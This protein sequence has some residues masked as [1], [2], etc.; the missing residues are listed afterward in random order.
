MQERAPTILCI[1]DDSE[2][3]ALR[4][5]FLQSSGYSVVTASSG[6]DGLRALSDGAG[7]DLVLLDYMMPGMNGDE[8]AQKLK[9][10]YP[11]LPV[12]VVSA[13][14]QLPERLSPVIDGYV[15]K[16][17]D[18][19][20][21][22]GTVSEILTSRSRKAAPMGSSNSG[23]KTVL[24]AE[25]DPDQ[26]TSRKL[27]FESA[28]FDVLLARSG[29]EALELFQRHP[30]DAVVLD[31]WMPRMKGLS[32][33]REMKRLRPNTPIMVFSGFSSLP[34]ETIGVVDTWLQKRDVE[35]DELLAEVKR[36]IDNARNSPD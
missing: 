33:A 25:D 18:P 1:D 19:D 23:R 11:E 2:T 35:P 4:R 28:G 8:V 26:L 27:V 34:D 31:Y 5:H 24:C 7:V 12:V 22:L 3:L 16:G 30:V 6:T 14:A 17:R 13:V 9:G 15:Q 10:Q 36:L 21:L 20:V 32:V 29:P